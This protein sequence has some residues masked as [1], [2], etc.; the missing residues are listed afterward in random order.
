MEVHLSNSKVGGGTGTF[1]KMPAQPSTS[2]ILYL[3]LATESPHWQARVPR[4]QVEHHFSK[5][6]SFLPLP[7]TCQVVRPPRTDQ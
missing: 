4:T 3:M 2:R 5:C 6:V 1:P 7:G